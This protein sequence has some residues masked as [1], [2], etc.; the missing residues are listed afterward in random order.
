MEHRRS[1]ASLARWSLVLRVACWLAILV[2]AALGLMLAFSA[3]AHVS[4]TLEPGTDRPIWFQGQAFEMDEVTA[5][6][7]FHEAPILMRSTLLVLIPIVIWLLLGLQTV[8]ARMGAGDPFHEDNA[9][10]FR[11]LAWVV[12]VL[13]MLAQLLLPLAYANDGGFA[14]SSDAGVDAE[15]GAYTLPGV[16]LDI[17][18]ILHFAGLRLLAALIDLGRR[19]PRA[20]G[21]PGT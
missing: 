15:P 4:L 8:F 9:D 2:V 5:H 10:Y 17:T 1:E 13:G 20:E 3:D 12:L 16:V 6:Q 7:P 14:Y 18:P 19:G 21:A 11:R